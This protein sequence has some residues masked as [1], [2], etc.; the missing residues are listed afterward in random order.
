MEEPI[1]IQLH[2]AKKKNMCGSGYYA[3]FLPPSLIFFLQILKLE[4]EKIH[5][6]MTIWNGNLN[7]YAFRF[8]QGYI[9]KNRPFYISFV[10]YPGIQFRLPCTP[11]PPGQFFMGAKSFIGPPECET[12]VSSKKIWFGLC[13]IAWFLWQPIANLRRGSAYKITP[14]SAVT[15]PRLLNLIPN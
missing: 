9:F 13:E 2:K 12:K 8:K 15:Y 3:K 6:K 11:P 4:R 10:L 1:S 14:I 5:I 7:F